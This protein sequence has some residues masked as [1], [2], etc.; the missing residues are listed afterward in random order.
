MTA[1]QAGAPEVVVAED[2]A[3]LGPLIRDVVRENGF[4]EQVSVVAGGLRELPSRWRHSA[5][6]V[7][8][9][10]IDAALL[11]R[12]LLDSARFARAELLAEG[13]ALIPRAARLFAA[14]VKLLLEQR[15]GFDLSLVDAYRGVAPTEPM[16]LVGQSKAGAAWRPLAEPRETAAFE[17]SKGIE[18]ITERVSFR[19]EKAETVNALAAWYT[20]ELDDTQRL[21]NAPRERDPWRLQAISFFAERVELAVDE[22]LAFATTVNAATGLGF[23]GLRRAQLRSYGHTRGTLPSWHIPMLTDTGRNDVFVEAIEQVLAQRPNAQVLD[24]GAGSGLLALAAAR[25]GAARV[26]AC[27]MVPH[28]A[29]LAEACVAHNGAADKVQ[30]VARASF[31]LLVPEDMPQRAD[32]LVSETL[33]HGLLGERFLIALAHAREHLLTDDATVIPASA[34]LY[35]T[36]IDLHT[37]RVRGFDLR[38][39]DQLCLGHYA[40]MRLTDAPHQLLSEPQAVYHFDFQSG[41]LEPA[42]A[43]FPLQVIR[44]GVCSGVALWFDLQL[45]AETAL[46]TAPGAGSAAWDQGIVFFDQTIDVSPGDVLP[47]WCNHDLERVTIYPDADFLREHPHRCWP[48]QRALWAM[49]VR[50]E[51]NARADMGAGLARAMGESDPEHLE[52]IWEALTADDPALHWLRRDL[53]ADLYAQAGHEL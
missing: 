3:Y 34:T 40:G 37:D 49:A 10:T 52:R 28:I 51:A 16:D 14:P 25:A 13:G 48:R 38:L 19:L 39:I 2:G 36:P 46:S 20:L 15:C 8:L 11:G 18:R 21:D 7:V 32:V 47:I 9:D 26:T 17:F 31:D 12:G 33:D 1:A 22:E 4:A 43:L 24:I 29:E 41:A 30:I 42:E 35:M 45:T 27:E 23:A 6:L 44:A 5:D 53:L 50:A